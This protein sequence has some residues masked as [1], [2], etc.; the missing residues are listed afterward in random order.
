MLGKDQS[1]TSGQGSTAVTP[2][3]ARQGRSSSTMVFRTSLTAYA[4]TVPAP[5]VRTPASVRTSRWRQA[6]RAVH[7]SISPSTTSVPSVARPSSEPTQPGASEAPPATD[8]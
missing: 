3:S 2:R 6:V 7:I 8:R 5:A 1:P 4:A